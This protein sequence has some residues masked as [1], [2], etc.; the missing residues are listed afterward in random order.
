MSKNIVAYKNGKRII[1]GSVNEKNE[2]R[3]D[4]DFDMSLLSRK[5]RKH[6]EEQY[7]IK[8]RWKDSED[9]YQDLILRES[10]FYRY[11]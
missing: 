2:F 5:S 1:I 10:M 3:Y 8:Y 6:L 4:L 7:T 11:W 9:W